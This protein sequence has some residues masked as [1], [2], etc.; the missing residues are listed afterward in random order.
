MLALPLLG[1]HPNVRDSS[2]S[3]LKD[4]VQ[5]QQK[6]ATT[7]A[8]HAK[9]I[10]KATGYTYPVEFSI[11]RAI[12]PDRRMEVLG[13]VVDSGR[14]KVF[15]WIA[16][17]NEAANGAT[18]KRFPQLEAQANADEPFEVSGSS[19]GIGNT[20]SCGPLNSTFTPER[21]KVYLVEFQFVGRG[22][23]QHV[24]DVTQPGQRIPVISKN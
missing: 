11:R 9:V 2:P 17:L 13:T 21:R 23:E 20:Y 15:G 10:M 3:L 4:G 12:E 16:K 7:D 22:C 8:Q 24:Y 6:T 1:C 14:G 19:N 18:F 5:L